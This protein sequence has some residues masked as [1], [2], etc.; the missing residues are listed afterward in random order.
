M[1]PYRTCCLHLAAEKEVC[2]NPPQMCLEHYWRA[3]NKQK[4]DVEGPHRIKHESSP[5]R[6]NAKLH[7]MAKK[8]EIEMKGLRRQ[9]TLPETCIFF[10]FSAFW[11]G[12]KQDIV[13]GRE[14]TWLQLSLTWDRYWHH[15]SESGPSKSRT[16]G[17]SLGINWQATDKTGKRILWTLKTLKLKWQQAVP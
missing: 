10:F 12:R 4:T 2:C 6:C 7:S 15:T 16:N 14:D 5:Q 8:G 1:K 3:T 11:R 9:L 17:L 13:R